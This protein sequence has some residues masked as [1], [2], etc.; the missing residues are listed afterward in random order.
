MT[1]MLRSQGIPTKLNVGY[2]GT[3]YHA[4]ISCWLKE[5]GWV[6]NIIYFDGKEWTLMDP[7][8]AASETDK[9]KLK[10]FIGDGDNYIVQYAY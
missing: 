5:T 10:K 8:L 2:A 9:R 1:A 4:W 7:T 3:A 6:E